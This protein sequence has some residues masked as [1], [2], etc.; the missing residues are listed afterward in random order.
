ML[1]LTSPNATNLEQLL[2]A[3]TAGQQILYDFGPFLLRISPHRLASGR[4]NFSEK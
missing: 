1:A 3:N 4:F 2:K